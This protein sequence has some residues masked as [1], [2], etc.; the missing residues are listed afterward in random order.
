MVFEVNP[1]QNTQITLMKQSWSLK[2]AEE[3]V[4]KSCAAFEPLSL[5]AALLYNPLE[6]QSV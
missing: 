3:N 6:K 1:I 4:C 2:Q 5:T